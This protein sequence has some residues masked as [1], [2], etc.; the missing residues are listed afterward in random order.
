MDIYNNTFWNP[1]VSSGGGLYYS[2][3]SYRTYVTSSYDIQ[4]N[5]IYRIPVWIGS[6]CGI[7]G[8]ISNSILSGTNPLLV[9][10]NIATPQTYFQL[11]S[12]SPARNIGLTSYAGATG[13]ITGNIDAGAYLYGDINAF[14]PGYVA[15]DAEV[16]GEASIDDASP[17][18]TKTGVWTLSQNQAW[19]VAYHAQTLSGTSDVTA[20]LS[21]PFTG[22]HIE[23]WAE[24]RT[25]HGIVAV[26]IDGVRQ[27]CDTGTGGTQDC[28]LYD[29]S[30]DNLPAKI[31]EKDITQ[32]AHTIELRATGTR[33]ASSTANPFFDEFVHDR[34]FFETN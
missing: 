29:S 20:K 1:T 23:W 31:F 7:N 8:N 21:A 12:G 6:C 25:N 11:Q 19:T 5:N 2:S 28:D 30:T 3:A 27:D 15:P 9:A 16:P 22:D 18:N 14:I 26:Y 4:R 10:D 13:Q 17:S 32:G 34:F 24:K 33:N